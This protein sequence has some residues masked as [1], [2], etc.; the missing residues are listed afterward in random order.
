MKATPKHLRIA[1]L[2]FAIMGVGA[3]LAFSIDYGPDNPL[4]Y[5]ALG[6]GIIGFII[7]S[8]AIPLGAYHMFSRRGVMSD[9]AEQAHQHKRVK[10]PWDS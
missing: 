1:F 5:L 6:I 9:R 8:L 4:S 10:Q 7:C 3:A 2:G